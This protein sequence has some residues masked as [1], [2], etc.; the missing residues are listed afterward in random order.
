MA[1]TVPATKVTT[2]A[3][4]A[5]TNTGSGTT[6]T[7]EAWNIDAASVLTKLQTL[8]TTANKILNGG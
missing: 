4:M 6:K 3:P 1:T 7:Q 5:S 8:Q 2:T